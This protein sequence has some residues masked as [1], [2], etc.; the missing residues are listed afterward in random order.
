VLAADTREAQWRLGRAV[1]VAVAS[2]RAVA[3]VR[4]LVGLGR[5]RY[6]GNQGFG[7]RGPGGA[8]LSYE[9]GREFLEDAERVRDAPAHRVG[10]APK[11]PRQE[12]LRDP[13]AHR[14]G[15]GRAAQ[16]QLDARAS[17]ARRMLPLF[18]GTA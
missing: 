4:A 15:Q 10:S 16:C 12:G 7:I 13:A 9:M 8:A 6:D 5:H 11:A 3:D 17:G 18:W 2:G 1:T 14:L